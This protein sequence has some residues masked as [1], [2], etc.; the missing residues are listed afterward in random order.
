VDFNL[1]ESDKFFLEDIDVKGNVKTKSTVIVRELVLAP[2]DVFDTN[3]M[4]QSE[5]RLRNLGYFNNP[6]GNSM[7]NLAPEEGNIP[8]KRNLNITVKEGKT[9]DL[10]FGAGFDSVQSLVAYVEFSQ[11]NFDLF[12]YRN[13]F[14]GGGEKARIKLSVGTESNSATLSFENPWLWERELDGGIDLFRNETDYLSVTFNEVDLGF[15]VFLRKHLFQLNDGSYIDGTVTY[16]LEDISLN[17]VTTDAVPQLIAEQGTRSVSELSFDLSRAVLDNNVTPTDGT[18]LEL[19]NDVAGG[20]LAGQTNFYRVEARAGIWYPLAD[21]GDQVVS[22]VT[23]GGTITGYGGKTVPYAEKYFLGGGYNLRGYSYR[24]V[25]PHEA[26]PN[27]LAYGQPLGG[28]TFFYASPEWSIEVFHPVRFAVFYDV[29]FVNQ[30]SFDFSPGDFQQDAGIG[31]RI[32]LFGAPLRIDFGYPLNANLYQS[33][34]IQ[35]NFSFG[36]VF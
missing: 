35:F 7:V 30:D 9:G 16:T 1:V 10:N 25:G 4:K 28:N 20:P 33:H 15:D 32:M 24:N 8:G 21:F 31:F 29:G 2:G 12:N 27:S 3:R 14:E 6:D 23:R 13:Y 18:R 5:S 34:G 19:L 36:T 17:D 26:D 22:F 11:S